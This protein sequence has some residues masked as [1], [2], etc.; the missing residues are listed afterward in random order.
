VT[1]PVLVRGER[2]GLT[3]WEQALRVLAGVMVLISFGFAVVYF[4]IGVFG[5]GEFPFSVNSVAKDGLLG[6]LAL[7]IIW[8]V[9][10]WAE[11]AVPLI[12][13]AHVVMPIVLLATLHGDNAS[14][15]ATWAA[16]GG[17]PFEMLKPASPEALRWGWL[18]SDVAM[19]VFF[20]WFHYM[21]IKSRYDVR[22]LTPG[23][24]RALMALSEVLV[25][26][27]DRDE[28]VRPAEVA[29]RADH[30]LDSFSAQQKY[31]IKF[32]F[33][34]LAL[35]PLPFLPPFY[36]MSRTLRQRWV[37][38]LFLDEGRFDW[39]LPDLFL[40]MRRAMIRAAQQVCFAG[41]YGDEGAAEKCG[42]LPF[43]RR[44][45]YRD[46]LPDA[47]RP[48]G[49]VKCMG[50]D[51]IGGE[52][53]T[54]PLVIVGS[55]AAAAML[56]HEL[57]DDGR[58]IL[59]LERGKH[60]DPSTFTENEGDQLSKLYADGALTLS[61]DFRFQVAQG[62]CVG[63]STVVNN[64][65]CFDLPQDAKERWR[66]LEAG[67]DEARL[68][69]AFEYVRDFLRVNTLEPADR[70]NPGGQ[71]VADAIR[72]LPPDDRPG[73]EF[74]VVDANIV[75]CLGSG[76]CNIGCKFGAKLSALDWTL[77]KAQNKRPGAV[78]VLPDCRVEKVLI[79]DRR[80]CGVVA[81]LGDGRRLT[82]HAET[83][84][85]SAGAIASSVIL[86]R[87]GLGNG[88][89]GKSLAFNIAS[90]VTLDFERELH[91]ERG[92]Q[93]SHYFQPTPASDDSFEG[94]ELETWWNPIVSQSL[95]MPGWFEQHW[96]N[97]RRYENMT[98]LGVVVGSESNGSVS[99][100]R[101]GSG[102]KLEYQPSN[103]DFI[104][105]KDGV[106]LACKIGLR[107]GALRAMPATFRMLE[108]TCES[109]LGRIDDEIGSDRDISINS[110][111]PQ[112]GNP[113][114]ED[115]QKGVVA[116]DFHV[117]G[118]Q[119]LYV[120]DASV[121]PSSITVNPQLTVMALA[122]Y[123]ADEIGCAKRRQRAQQAEPAQPALSISQAGPSGPGS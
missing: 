115:P 6:G 118:T 30:Y 58:E 70:R 93:M 1:N 99:A 109:E 27:P 65:V 60:V 82:V 10:R 18:A 34:A 80:A 22:Y 64:A 47:R 89:A 87:S 14:I 92:A 94:L 46:R 5:N 103:R 73:G 29:V 67:L 104:R 21:A 97:M 101:F 45:E 25:L 81:R 113:M 4:Y 77:P 74:N 19:V 61:K 35:W 100:A 110:S 15:D 84:V 54:A 83:V 28:N 90:P 95:F 120:C 111:H 62:M 112:G 42:Y 41:Y 86:Q 53:L 122:A 31:R 107:A 24:F 55:G 96:A 39:L 8:D 123:A 91:S 78:R 3:G 106:R 32:A 66:D 26:G 23:G 88:L 75:R 40:E 50:P 9:R 116:P 102:V 105:L 49:R 33:V 20:V 121:F 2:P 68:T 98:C 52:N 72:D 48:A 38:R 44:E 71:Y 51:D 36:V 59:L 114:S 17:T 7:L 85:L 117:Y 13:A 16:V 108:V 37:Q 69:N 79:R 11:V 12:V 119:G 63:G 76:Y 43:S 57:A 56:A